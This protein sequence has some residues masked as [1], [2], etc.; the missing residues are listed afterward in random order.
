MRDME[1][2]SFAEE[3]KCGAE[4]R[5]NVQKRTKCLKLLLAKCKIKTHQSI[6]IMKRFKLMRFLIVCVVRNQELLMKTAPESNNLKQEL[7]L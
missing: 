6:V 2:C 1:L 5:K 4:S 3:K 7:H